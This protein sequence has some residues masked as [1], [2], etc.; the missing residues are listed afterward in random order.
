M[1]SPV[2]RLV[3]GEG[4]EAFQLGVDRDELV[5][6]MR[7]RADEAALTRP[8]LRIID[9]SSGLRVGDTVDVAIDRRPRGGVRVDIGDRS[10]LHGMTTGRG[11]S[12]V[13]Y[14]GGVATAVQPVVD[15]AWM[16]LLLVPFGWWATSPR[17]LLAGVL[18]FLA[19][20]LAVPLWI[21]LLPTTV[22]QAGAAVVGAVGGRVARVR[23]DAVALHRGPSGDGDRA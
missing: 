17:A 1:L 12:L 4:R 9:W 16:L 21:P 2:L 5:V 7:Y 23:L 8:E 19:L 10:A 14:T 20:V 6:R 3:D 22:T 15:A 11:W 13:R 18:G